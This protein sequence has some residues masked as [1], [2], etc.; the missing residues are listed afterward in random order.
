MRYLKGT[1]Q[2]KKKERNVLWYIPAYIAVIILLGIFSLLIK[3]D[4]IEKVWAETPIIS[5][6]AEP[7]PAIQLPT[8]NPNLTER[9]QNMALIKKIW[10]RDA[11]IG[12][13]IA[14]CESGYRTKTPYRPNTNGTQDQGV[15]QIN[16]VHNMTDME[17]A[18]ANIS[19]AYTK[20][21]EQG[22]N[23]WNS[24]KHCWE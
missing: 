8:L 20:F 11:G 7:T 6:L 21:L 24:S 22:T 15:F 9:E 19:Y 17:N 18:V 12:L 2:Y 14:R 10:G 1:N 4:T 3:K 16:T 23:P 5:P 13:E